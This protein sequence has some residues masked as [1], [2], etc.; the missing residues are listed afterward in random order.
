MLKQ[1]TTE[2]SGNL[3]RYT[4]RQ[5]QSMLHHMFVDELQ[6]RVQG[7]AVG[8]SHV[9]VHASSLKL[10]GPSASLSPPCKA[11]CRRTLHR[12]IA[13]HACCVYYTTASPLAVIPAESPS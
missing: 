2:L 3:S 12:A 8:L 1:P 4:C 6:V 13:F 7:K 5:M 11:G 10:S 9:T